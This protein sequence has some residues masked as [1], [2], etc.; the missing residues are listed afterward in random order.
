M[1]LAMHARTLHP[2]RGTESRW[3]GADRRGTVLVEFALCLPVALL[4]TFGMIDM[5]RANMLR[6]T[7]ENAAYEGARA[8]ITPGATAS[9]A[10]AAASAVMNAIAAR[11]TTITVSPSF[12]TDATTEVTVTVTVPIAL[13]LWASKVFFGSRQMVRSC[14]L[15]RELTNTL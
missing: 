3:N 5:A 8:G 9:R 11:G 7:A 14:T 4:I 1:V 12:I 6:N 10:E 13:N 2:D 15:T